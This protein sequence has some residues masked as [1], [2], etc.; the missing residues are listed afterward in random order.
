MREGDEGGEWNAR[1]RK[2][3]VFSFFGLK[4]AIFLALLAV[5]LLRICWERE[6]RRNTSVLPAYDLTFALPLVL[7]SSLASYPSEYK[8]VLSCFV[9][10]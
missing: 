4:L 7:L 2:G 6:N 9:L 10:Q 5:G 1:E 8:S 3:C